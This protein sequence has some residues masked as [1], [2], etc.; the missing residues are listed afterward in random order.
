ML[1]LDPIQLIDDHRRWLEAEAEHERL[2]AQLPHRPS[3]AEDVRRGLALA[4]YRLASWLDAP[5]GYV[6]LPEAGP[7]DWATPWASV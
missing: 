4:C 5:A 6:Q 3:P 2:V 1:N 7:E